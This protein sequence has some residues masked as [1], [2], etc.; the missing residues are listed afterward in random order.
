M[1]R[2]SKSYKIVEKAKVDLFHCTCSSCIHTWAFWGWLENDKQQDTDS[3]PH[4]QVQGG[5][6]PATSE[7]NLYNRSPSPV[8]IPM[9]NLTVP[10]HRFSAYDSLMKRRTEINN[11]VRSLIHTQ[12]TC[13]ITL[14]TLFHVFHIYLSL[15]QVVPTHYTMRSATL[16][17]PSRKDFIE[18][19]TKQLDNCQKVGLI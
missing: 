16:G 2:T 9:P 10:R 14:S 5:L 8:G 1:L 12:K 19:L 11:T 6:S 17:A 13:T 18:E 15:P 4:L 3:P 7:M